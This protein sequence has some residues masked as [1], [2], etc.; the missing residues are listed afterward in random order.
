MAYSRIFGI[1][2]IQYVV[3]FHLWDKHISALQINKQCKKVPPTKYQA[4]ACL[5]EIK[6]NGTPLHAISRKARKT[7]QRTNQIFI[8]IAL[9]CSNW[10]TIAYLLLLKLIP[11]Y[12]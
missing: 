8:Q 4:K 7:C 5:S 11:F 1:K 2:Y 9:I 3:L 12:H 10:R 6:T